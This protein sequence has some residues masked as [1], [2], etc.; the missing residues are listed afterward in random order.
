MGYLD[1]SNEAAAAV[2]YT[3]KDN[4]G[5]KEITSSPNPEHAVWVTQD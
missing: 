5:K 3:E 4:T 1:G 2:I